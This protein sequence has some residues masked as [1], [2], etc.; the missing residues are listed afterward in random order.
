MK[1]I[2]VLLLVVGMVFST[3]SCADSQNIDGKHYTPYGVFNQYKK[4]D[5]IQYRISPESVVWSTITL[6]G[7]LFPVILTGWYLWEPICEEHQPESLKTN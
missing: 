3:T 5:D 1:R 2:L 6:P 7:I 4:S